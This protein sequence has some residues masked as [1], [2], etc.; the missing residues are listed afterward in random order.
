MVA[1]GSGIL[2]GAR[3][4]RLLHPSC[5]S[6][7]GQ[8]AASVTDSPRA[9]HQQRAQKLNGTSARPVDAIYGDVP[10]RERGMEQEGLVPSRQFAPHPRHQAYMETPEGP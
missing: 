7:P 5:A 8:L 2:R 4:G 3:H 6:R 9:H 1:M 10:Y